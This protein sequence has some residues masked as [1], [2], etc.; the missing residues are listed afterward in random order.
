[1]NCAARNGHLAVVQYLHGIGATCTDYA[2]D[3]AAW[4][5]HLPVV[6]YLHG[7]GASYTDAVFA[8]HRRILHGLRGC[9]T[10]FKKN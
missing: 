1:M 3:W 2:M 6:Q 7:I 4:N 8:R 10:L 9:S 5:G